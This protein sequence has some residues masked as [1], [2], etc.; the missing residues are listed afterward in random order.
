[1]EEFTT[2]WR[3]TI[4]GILIV[5]ILVYITYNYLYKPKLNEIYSLKSSLKLI[6]SE[7]M[8]ADGG[9]LLLKDIGTASA[10]L[11]KELDVLAKKIPS[12][13][14]TPYLIN[15]FTSV[16]GKGLNIDYNLIQPSDIVPEQKYKR[17][18]LKV[19]F[20]GKYADLNTYLAQLKKLPV[21]IRVDSLDLRKMSGTKK[22][23][24]SMMLSAFVMPGGAEKPSAAIKGYTYLYDPFYAVREKSQV[25]KLEPVKGLR[26]SGY[27]LG[28][29]VRAVINDEVLKAGESIQGF[30]VLKIYRDRVV[31]IKD[32]KLYDLTIKEK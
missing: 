22:L 19:E 7:I 18:P 8:M 5:L 27:F 31:L 2:K 10:L 20:E 25:L 12:E 17:L 32:K 15:N 9:S 11:K 1:M 3:N 13:T 4:A 29:E 28:K 24:V 30:K 23:A 6:D 21:T 16:V 26:Y 14:Q